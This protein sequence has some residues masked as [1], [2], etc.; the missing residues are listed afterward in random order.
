[1]I[2]PVII[3]ITDLSAEGTKDHLSPLRGFPFK[4]D[5]LKM[6]NGGGSAVHGIA[7]APFTTERVH[8]LHDGE[9]FGVGHHGGF[10]EAGFDAALGFEDL[11]FVAGD[12]VDGMVVGGNELVVT[13]NLYPIG[14]ID[15]VDADV[16]FGAADDAA[17]IVETKGA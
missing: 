15:V 3:A 10:E 5:F 6:K 4:Q 7:D 1:M 8:L 14:A 11:V 2:I 17:T 13:P 16:A 9:G 12:H